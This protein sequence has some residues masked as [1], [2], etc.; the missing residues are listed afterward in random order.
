MI[1]CIMI[2]SINTNIF[3]YMYYINYGKKL[4]LSTNFD[5]IPSPPPPSPPSPLSFSENIWNIKYYFL[6]RVFW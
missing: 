2:G 4:V 1:I 5:N 3:S 6:Q